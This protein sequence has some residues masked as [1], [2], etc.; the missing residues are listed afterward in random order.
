MLSKQSLR[1]WLQMVGK[2]A[3]LVAWRH[4]IQHND[5]QHYDIQYNDTQHKGLVWA[6]HK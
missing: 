5:T 4:D 6:Q 1:H 2:E 3:Q